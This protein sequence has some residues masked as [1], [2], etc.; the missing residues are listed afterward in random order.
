MSSDEN[1]PQVAADVA[2]AG[3]QAL[4]LAADVSMSVRPWEFSL[5]TT[6]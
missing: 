6:D 1:H 5:S 3:Y 2:V 4:Q